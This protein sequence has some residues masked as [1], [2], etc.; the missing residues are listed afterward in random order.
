MGTAM[1]NWTPLFDRGDGTWVGVDESGDIGVGSQEHIKA[2]VPISNPVPLWPLLERDFR[3]VHELLVSEW[4]RLEP[5]GRSRPE[6]L[7]EKIIVSAMGSG[8]PYW[9]ERAV[10]WISDM[11]KS[12]FDEILLTSHLRMIR[13]DTSMPQ[14][15]RHRAAKQSKRWSQQE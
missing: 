6:Q 15:L 3:S 9:V 11:P 2:K 14:A 13:V 8:S 7:I 5:A 1:K 12:D 4:P 10:A